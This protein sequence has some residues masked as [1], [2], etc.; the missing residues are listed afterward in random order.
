MKSLVTLLLAAVAA[1]SAIAQPIPAQHVIVYAE[2]GRFGGWPANCGIWNWGDEILVAFTRSWFKENADSHSIDRERPGGMAFARSL[3]GG[4]TWKIEEQPIFQQD[5]SQAPP[6]P[7]GIDFAHPDFALRIRDR[8][9]HFSYDRGRTWQG[10][11]AFPDFGIG[12]LTSRTDYLVQGRDDCLLF[13]SAK[14]EQVQ[15]D[16]DELKDR[17]FCARTRDGGKT[18][19]FVG[20][21]SG[22]PLSIRSVM[23]STVRAAD[24]SLVTTLRRRLDL[25]SGYRNDLNW[26]DAYGSP[27]DGKNWKFLAR[28]GYVDT[29][30]HNGNPPSLVRLPD[31]RLAAAWGVRSPP[32]G[33][34]GRVSYD[35]GVTWGPELVLRDDAR[36]FDIGY[37]RSV[38]RK[39][40]RIVTVY[41][42]TTPERPHNYIAATIWTAPAN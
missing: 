27:D 38:V 36:K 24:G 26:I 19:E 28:L 14:N 22:P 10:P 18:F 32:F 1:L 37:C 34:H 7:G 15:V 33:I 42:Y 40:G 30:D 6:S 11:F 12:R 21:M 17:A 4:Q 35:N 25:P 9:F 3:D 2:A 5:A 39:D 8:A 31:G 16:G 23:P 20:W 13:F 41:Y 29:S